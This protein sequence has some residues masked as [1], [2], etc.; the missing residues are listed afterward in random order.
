MRRTAGVWLIVVGVLAPLVPLLLWS[1]SSHWRYPSL[2]P[3]QLTGR[4]WRLLTDP[5]SEVLTGLL[6]STA[7]GLVVTVLAVAIGLPAG[8]ALGLYDF[9]GKQVVRFLL[10]A[11][12]L[13]PGLAVLLGTQ[14]VFLR[15]GLA[16]TAAGVVLVQLIPTVPYVTMVLAGAY[17][18]F[19]V[20]Y[21]QQARLLGA[22]PGR[23]FLH[24]TVP[25]LKPALAVAGY[26]A[27]LISWSEY[28]L[29]FLIG[30]GQVKTLPL[31]LFAYAQGTDLTQAAAVAVLLLAPPML[32][33]AVLSRYLP[34]QHG[35]LIGLGRL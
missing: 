26:F 2:L 21:E 11:P 8:R 9:R 13:V 29:T 30:G 33:L 4:G 18:N 14:V 19:D 23:A 35:P 5:H 10:L 34:D 28:V 20:R 31:L 3:G 6:T 16:D 22:G 24:V 32:L 25:S 27:F 15:L 12:V 1:V 17:E 7:I